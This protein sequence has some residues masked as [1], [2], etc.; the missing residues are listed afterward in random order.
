MW[1]KN[2]NASK[3]KRK[4]RKY[5]FN[6]PLHV[7]QKFVA[8]HLAPEL[9]K[10]YGKRSLSVRK[11]DMV[12]ILRGQFKGKS[13]KVVEVDLKKSKVFVE[14][15]ENIRKDGNKS[16]YPLHP[17]NLMLTELFLE[18][19]KRLKGLKKEEKKENK[20]TKKNG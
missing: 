18:D 3:S 12:K 17:S 4:Q 9:R 20:G 19:R 6:A 1:N 15:I 7:R 14:G 5:L 10:K 16:L 13:G 11:E 8:V 2:W